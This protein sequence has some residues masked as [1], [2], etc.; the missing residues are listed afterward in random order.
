[1]II[2]IHPMLPRADRL[3]QYA[4]EIYGNEIATYRS[5]YTEKVPGMPQIILVEQPDP[6]ST[7]L[8]HYHASDQF[9]V[10]MDGDGLLGKHP[11]NPVSVHYTNKFTGYGPIVA[12]DAGVSY[13]VLR[14]A[15]DPLGPGQYLHHPE[16]REQAK[17]YTGKRRTLVA[18]GI[19]IETPAQLRALDASSAQRLFDVPATEP[20]AGTF[21]E[22]LRLSPGARH[23]GADPRSGGG[24]VYLVMQGTCLYDGQSLG[25]R[26]AIA[27]TR[28]EAPLE[29]AAGRD[30]AQLLVMQ[31]PVPRQNDV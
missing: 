8:P 11:L 14:P 16:L 26:A 27:V 10:F 25:C 23:V 22:V 18:D 24:Q 19:V 13:Y 5:T 6:G 4:P 20:D 7:L 17:R 15:P 9:Q 21:A 28:D 2:P 12:G 1:M 3:R 30:G 31:Y 29:I